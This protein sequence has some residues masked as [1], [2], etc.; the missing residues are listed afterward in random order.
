MC[1]LHQEWGL[2]RYVLARREQRQRY[3]W[4]PGNAFKELRNLKVY[5]SVGVKKNP[6]VHISANFGQQPFMFDID[7][8]V[9]VGFRSKL[10]FGPLGAN[11]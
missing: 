8:M 11:S 2:S 1:F 3:S 5:P 7:G 4:Y 6:P 10:S 9:K